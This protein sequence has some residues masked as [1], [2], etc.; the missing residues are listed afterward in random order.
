MSSS[1]KR[2]RCLALAL[3]AVTLAC[4]PAGQAASKPGSAATAQMARHFQHEDALYS[5]KGAGTVAANARPVGLSVQAYRAQVI[6]GEALNKLYGLDQSA[7]P[8]RA[9]AIRA[10]ALDR[11]YGNAWTRVSPAEF[12]S[13]VSVFGTQVTTTMTLQQARAE[14]A[15]GQGLNRW[16]K[17]YTV[18]TM[19]T[20]KRADA[21][22]FH[23]EHEDAIYSV[24]DTGAE[25]RTPAQAMALHFEH[26]DAH[27]GAQGPAVA[28]PTAAAT[29][30]GFDWNDALVYAGGAVG[31]MLLSAAAVVAVHR[32]RSRLAQS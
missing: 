20:P 12:R 24:K 7:R 3:A 8:S 10:A 19:S 22:A 30:D 28:L 27:Y 9:D 6:R 23:F 14:L 29:S 32:G 31:V 21:M 13:L 15:R 25:A 11:R 4:I 18:A 5:V 16:A 1:L 2:I 17:Q 26:E